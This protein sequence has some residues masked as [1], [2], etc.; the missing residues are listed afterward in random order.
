MTIK[1]PDGSAL[2]VLLRLDAC[3]GRKGNRCGYGGKRVRDR[4]RNPPGSVIDEYITVGTIPTATRLGTHYHGDGDG[5][6][7][8]KNR[9]DDGYITGVITALNGLPIMRH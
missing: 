2:G 3:S 6:N 4:R 1:W 9:V 7:N 8:A 5:S